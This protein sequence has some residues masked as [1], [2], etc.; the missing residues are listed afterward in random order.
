MKILFVLYINVYI[1]LSRN[2]NS[3]FRSSGISA[4]SKLRIKNTP[5]QLRM[6]STDTTD[7]EYMK[8]TLNNL[9]SSTARGT[10]DNNKQEILGMVESFAAANAQKSSYFSPQD[11]LGDWE[12]LYTDDD[13]TRCE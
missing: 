8:G 3:L 10:N 13:I 4:F 5:F 2:A 7:V 11:L 12:L 6:V 1:M 9:I